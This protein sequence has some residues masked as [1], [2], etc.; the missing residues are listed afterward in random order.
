MDFISTVIKFLLVTSFV[1]HYLGKK[2]C[3][4]AINYWSRLCKVHKS[5]IQAHLEKA[6]K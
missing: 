3:I 4:N 5:K 6:I 1:V 2:L